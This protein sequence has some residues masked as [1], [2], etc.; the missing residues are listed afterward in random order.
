MA[1]SRSLEAHAL[2]V[3]VARRHGGSFGLARAR[4]V[5]SL[6][7]GLGTD[8]ANAFGRVYRHRGLTESEQAVLASLQRKDARVNPSARSPRKAPS[9]N[10]TYE[11]VYK[12]QT[13][14]LEHHGGNRYYLNGTFYKSLTAA[15]TAI[16]GSHLSGKAFW[17]IVE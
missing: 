15:A 16:T 3:A 6:P 7:F 13:Y 9:R 11:R 4:V 8:H 2:E 17:G 1:R 14:R 5:F 10:V 12:G